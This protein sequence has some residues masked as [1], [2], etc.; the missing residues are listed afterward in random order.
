M[1]NNRRNFLQTI[2]LGATALTLGSPDANAQI[3]IKDKKDRVTA[4]AN[5]AVADTTQGKVRGYIHDG[6][7]NFKGI[8]YGESTAGAYRFMP[9]VKPISWTGVRDTLTYG[10]ICPQKPNSGWGM[11]EYAFLYQWVDGFQSEDCLRLNVWTPTLKDNKKRPVLF[12]IH[13]GAFFS[14]SSQ[15]HPSYDGENLSRKGDVVVVSVNHRL[16]ALG[17]LDLSD[18]GSQYERSGN[19]GMLDLVAALEWV[20]DNIANFGGDAGNVTIFGQSGGG[21][22]VTTLMA[23]PTAKG[24]FH[25]AISQSSSTVQVAT[26]AYAAEL[27]GHFLSE[28]KIDKANIAQISKLP[29]SELILASIAAEKKM[30][31]DFPLNV[32]RA[33]W[34]PVVDGK[35]IPT[36]PFDPS[37]PAYSAH[38]PMIIGTNRNEASA[39]IGNAAMESLDD[40]GL[41]KKL[42][43]RF[44]AKSQKIHQVLRKVHPEVKAVEILSYVSPYNPMAYLQAE[45]KAAQNAA[46]VYLYLFAW[47]TPVLDSRPRSFHCSEI[48]FVFANTDRCETMTGGGQQARDLAAKISMAWLNFARTGNPDHKGLPQWKPFTK[49]NGATMVFNNNSEIRND[50]DGEARQLLEHLFYQRD[51]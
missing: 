13:G 19:V 32:G 4:S 45:R 8:P 20:R 7:Y 17:F 2:G 43:E 33:G 10:P 35:V 41:K 48:P 44:G 28:L 16:N 18:Y 15:E 40:E 12:W 46:P 34:Q 5:Q 24:L 14:G 42:F 39:S 50:P 36:H 11:Q 38:I 29:F 6:I 9:P 37:V 1:K 30:G 27:A 25:K 22:K 21:A 49:Q 31:S 51:L 47:Q 26:H 23:M 3:S